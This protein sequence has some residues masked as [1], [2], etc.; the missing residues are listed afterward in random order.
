QAPKDTAT[1]FSAGRVFQTL[2]S[3]LAVVSAASVVFGLIISLIFTVGYLSVFDP[4]LIWFIEYSDIIKIGLLS[5]AFLSTGFIIAV[6]LVSDEI[7]NLFSRKRAFIL[8][9]SITLFVLTDFF[10]NRPVTGLSYSHVWTH[11]AL[12]LAAYLILWAAYVMW[13]YD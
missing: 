6:G 8:A 11:L 12:A 5:I 13:R 1:P 2:S 10:L 4:M 7:G 9:C 3:N